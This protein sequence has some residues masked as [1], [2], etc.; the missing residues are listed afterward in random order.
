MIETPGT[1]LRPAEDADAERIA[2]IF[3]DEG[4]P[5]GPSAIVARLARFAGPDSQVVVA[6]REGEVIGFIAFHVLPRFEHDDVVVRILALVVD[7]GARERGLGHDLMA[8]A[9]RFARERGAAF[10]EVTAGR[11]RADARHLYESLGYDASVTAY[12]RKRL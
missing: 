7:A 1:V 6:D 10:I 2:A 5:A 8:E 11:H 4:Y 12:L 3:T 9:E